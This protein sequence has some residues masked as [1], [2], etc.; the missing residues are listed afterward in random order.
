MAQPSADLVLP[1]LEFQWICRSC[2]SCDRWM[3]PW[4]MS[5][6]N[7]SEHSKFHVNQILNFRSWTTTMFFQCISIYIYIYHYR[8]FIDDAF[9]CD[10]LRRF[11]NQSFCRHRDSPCWKGT[12]LAMRSYAKV[13][14]DLGSPAMECLWPLVMTNIAKWKIN[15]MLLMLGK[16]TISITIFKS[17]F[18]K[19]PEGSISL[20]YS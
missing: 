5:P 7:N 6:Q 18:D 3:S 15:T 19:L 8:G 11:F 17:Y 12:D 4:R 14:K 10:R 16:L 20:A 2:D 13:R 1:W 9:Y